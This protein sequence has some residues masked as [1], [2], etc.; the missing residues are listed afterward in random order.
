[1]KRFAGGILLMAS[2]SSAGDPAG[3]SDL[4]RDVTFYASFDQAVRADVGGGALEPSTR[5]NHKTEKGAFVFEKG[6]PASA[7]RIA[8]SAGVAGGALEAVDVLPDNGRLFFPAKG[9]LAVREGGWSAALSVW[10]NFDPDVQLKTPF[11]D[12]VQITQKGA[13]NGGLWFD[14]DGAKPRRN[15]RMGA[16]PAVPDGA[17][18]IA[19]SREAFSPMVWVDDPGFRVGA[20]RHVA[21]VWRN[22][23]SGR[24]DG[25]ASLYIDGKLRGEV[26]DKPYPLTM[27]WDLDRAGI[28]VAVSYIGLLDELALFGRAL[29]GDEIALLASRPDLLSPLR[30]R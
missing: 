10:I 29:D 12:P 17:K 13:G 24:P 11:C 6:F 26:M 27:G 15:L 2:C 8:P 19:E 4:L 22:L 14:F 20:W 25:R 23:D 1:M 9:N 18:P 5:F 21:L 30:R 7:F 3:S 28:Y 16:F